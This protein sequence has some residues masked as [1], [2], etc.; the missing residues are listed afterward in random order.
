MTPK[1]YQIICFG[2]IYLIDLLI[3]I[4]QF[5]K[6]KLKRMIHFY[7]L[8]KIDFKKYT[9]ESYIQSQNLKYPPNIALIINSFEFLKFSPIKFIKYCIYT[10]Q[11]KYITLYDPFNRLDIKFIKD[12]LGI[13]FED[14][15]IIISYKDNEQNQNII[16]NCQKN[17]KI[18]KNDLNYKKYDLI[19]S[20]IGF[21]SANIELIKKIFH[22]KKDEYIYPEESII[23]NNENK[24]KNYLHEYEKYFT[25]KIENNL[26]E[27]IITFG[28][29]SNYFNENIC[30]YGF[31]FTLLENSEIYNI[32]DIN[33]DDFDIISFLEI[34]T[35]NSLIQ[36]RFGS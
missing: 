19:I 36:K 15:N 28:N 16:F 12:N 35:K 27:L 3:S 5:F 31:P 10:K 1:P 8:Y 33:F 14:K 13:L 18:K 17:I 25:R 7:K 30:L 26:P 32:K 2:I 20:I 9:E 34:F 11:I 22:N 23:L 6:I 21:N 4:Y 24:S 29:C